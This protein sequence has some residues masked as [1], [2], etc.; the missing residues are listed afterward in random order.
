MWSWMTLEIG[1]VNVERL[2]SVASFEIRP[3]QRHDRYLRVCEAFEKAI[4]LG[5]TLACAYCYVVIIVWMPKRM[6]QQANV[7]IPWGRRGKMRK[8]SLVVSSSSWRVVQTSQRGTAKTRRRDRQ[9][10]RRGNPSL[11][12]SCL[13]R[14]TT[15]LKSVCITRSNPSDDS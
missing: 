14:R 8:R 9:K 7:L 10:R 13:L 12:R 6:C 5:A 11:Q 3:C 1:D 2:G 4:S 15:R